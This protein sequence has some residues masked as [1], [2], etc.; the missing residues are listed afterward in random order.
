MTVVLG[1]IKQLEK[2]EMAQEV[3][4]VYDIFQHFILLCDISHSIQLSHLINQ[5][6][7]AGIVPLM[8]LFKV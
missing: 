2:V 4:Q 5:P 6:S 8:F 3:G 1:D 7:L